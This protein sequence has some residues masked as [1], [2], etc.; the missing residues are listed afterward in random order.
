MTLPQPLLPFKI[1]L[2][3]D[4]DP[5]TA[6]A[7]LPLVLEALRAVVSKKSWR[8][9]RDALGYGSWRVVRRHVESL[10]LLV[11][12]GGEH[13]DHLDVLRGDL[14]LR[15]L[16][17]FELSSPTQAKDFLYRFHQAED[18]RPLTPKDDEALSVRGEA[19]IRAEGPGL[20]A[21][22]QIV[23]RVVEAV[24]RVRPMRAATLDVDA[25][26]VAAHKE[27]ALVAYEGTRGYQPQMAWWSEQGVW[28]CDEFRDGNVPAAYGVKGFLARAFGHVPDAIVRRRLR[29]DSALYDEE[30]LTW[31]DDQGIEFCVSAD[32]SE[33]LAAAV[34]ALPEGAWKPYRNLRSPDDASEERAYAEVCFVPN[35]PRNF[36]K[37]GQ[38]FRYV[39]IRVRSRQ[40]DLI[41]GGDAQW[42]HFAVVTNMD[43]EGGRLLNWHREK[44]GTVEQGHGIMKN[45]LAGGTLPCGRFAANAA[46]WRINVLVHDVLS[47]LKATALPAGLAS[48]RPRTLRFVLLH[49]PG[50]VVRHAR[51]W[52]LKLYAGFQYARAYV[53]ARERIAELAVLLRD[54]APAPA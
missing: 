15:A 8:V 20:V 52:V 37:N 45:D 26:I 47:L 6:H 12:G 18:G 34:R 5:V 22:G 33:A 48:A 49:L 27:L 23:L 7:A 10:V 44:Q 53:E 41:E 1:D 29:A 3:D 14:G 54:A 46:W 51:R 40:T 31:A 11:A 19:H 9:L 4:P 39:A 42:R 36:K 32:M 30:G 43:W 21:L 28:V 13:L 35:W 50:R 16:I 25:T 17:G 2:V 24:Q 38:P